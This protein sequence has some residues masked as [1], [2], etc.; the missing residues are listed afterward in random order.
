MSD[1]HNPISPKQPLLLILLPMWA[2]FLG[3]RLVLH[4]GG[5]RHLYPGGHL[6]HHFFFGAMLILPVAFLLIFPPRSHWLGLATLIALGIASALLLDEFVYL[7]AT[8]ATD[9][10]YVSRPSLFGGLTLMCCATLLLFAL[11]RPRPK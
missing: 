6:V 1:P 7:L 2:T 9:A 4:L 11:R 3:V 8:Q 10:D 5:V